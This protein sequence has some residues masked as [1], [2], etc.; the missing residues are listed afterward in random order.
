MAQTLIGQMPD[1][2]SSSAT[3]GL[4]DAVSIDAH[5]NPAHDANGP[6]EGPDKEAVPCCDPPRSPHCDKAAAHQHCP[7][8][9]RGMLAW[10]EWLGK[11]NALSSRCLL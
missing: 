11:H 7:V 4:P 1:Q 5:G 10:T 2:A 3:S 6:E 9:D 8:P